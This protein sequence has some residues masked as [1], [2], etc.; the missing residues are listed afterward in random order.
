MTLDESR[1]TPRPT[2]ALLV[3]EPVLLVQPRLAVLLGLDA[4][5]FLQQ[6]HY[7]LRR[8]AHLIDGRPW[9]YN[10]YPAWRKQLPFWSE[11][12]LGRLVGRLRQTG[13]LL[14]AQL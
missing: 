11:D 3:D 12:Q 13:V 9:I 4:A 10:S 2:S 14:T 6:V 8:S 1:P 5:L 7:W